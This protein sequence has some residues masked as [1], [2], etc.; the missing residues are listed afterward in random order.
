[1]NKAR[2]YL[3]GTDDLYFFIDYIECVLKQKVNIEQ[4]GK[5]RICTFGDNRIELLT[6]G[7]GNDKGGWTRLNTKPVQEDFRANMDDGIKTLVILDADSEKNKGGFSSRTA[8]VEKIKE[9]EEL[10]FSYF[11]IPNSSEDGDLEMLLRRILVE[12]YQPIL[13]CLDAYHEC[14]NDVQTTLGENEKLQIL[15][16]KHKIAVFRKVVKDSKR[17]N[18]KDN[19]IWNL[20]HPYL[21]PL[22][23]FIKTQLGLA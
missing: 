2:I 3:E 6:L 12:K 17:I 20:N 4:S 11:L 19:S 16:E 10:D 7:L 9:E 8:Q 22:K 15:N 14:L 21:N 18:Y 1:M 5:T 23:D 13:S